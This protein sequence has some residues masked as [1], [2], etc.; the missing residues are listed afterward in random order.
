M[1]DY[2]F[3]IFR[4]NRIDEPTFEL[5]KPSDVDITD[6]EDIK[7]IIKENSKND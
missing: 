1:P 3:I 6:I 2:R 5:F 7:R 4:S